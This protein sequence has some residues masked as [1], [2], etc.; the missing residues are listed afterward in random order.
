[1]GAVMLEPEYELPLNYHADAAIYVLA[2]SSGEGNDRLDQKGDYRLT[3]AEVRDILLLNEA[4]DKFMLVL[5][6]GGPVDLSEVAQVRNI[7]VLHEL[8]RNRRHLLQRG[9]LC[10]LSLF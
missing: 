2:R 6:T 3:D 7:L 1:M 4:Y 9:N 8:W 10:G 5:N